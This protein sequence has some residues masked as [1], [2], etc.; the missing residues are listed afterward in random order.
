L[1]IYVGDLYLST[2]AVQV[3]LYE[4]HLFRYPYGI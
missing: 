3:Q 2:A 4:A 1:T